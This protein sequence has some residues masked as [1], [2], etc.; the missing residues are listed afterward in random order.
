MSIDLIELP[1]FDVRNRLW[2]SDIFQYSIRRFDGSLK[3]GKL[4]VFIVH[5]NLCLS[6][7]YR[8]ISF[9]LFS[10]LND[11]GC[12][13][14]LIHV[15]DENYDQD[16]SVYYLEKCIFV[17]REYLRQ[18]G[19]TFK[20]I[21]EYVKSFFH[22]TYNNIPPDVSASIV[23]FIAYKVRERDPR[24]NWSIF[25]YLKR[26]YLPVT[27]PMKKI[28]HIP[29]GYTDMFGESLGNHTDVGQNLDNQIVERDYK[30]SFCGQSWKKDR[31]LMLQSLHG[32]EPKFVYESNPVSYE[33]LSGKDYYRIVSQ[34]IFIPC[35]FGNVNIDT[36]RLFEALEVGAIPI[37]LKGHAFQPYGYY[38][39]LLGNHPIPVF[40]SWKDAGRFMS[41]LTD[42]STIELSEQIR[43]WYQLFKVDLKVRIKEIISSAIQDKLLAADINQLESYCIP[44]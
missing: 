25:Q 10:H 15:L 4:P 44:R 9:Q 23:R 42:R 41:S 36:Y 24:G 2:I 21:E 17:F 28:F 29:L 32:I 13:F 11:C 43:R 35:P 7:D 6:P 8:S 16:L 37:I 27:L 38:N 26:Q 20:L 5:G 1:P 34:S 39:I 18:N 22:P 3:A 31:P 12:Y 30:W 33:M 40:S 19:G 14:G